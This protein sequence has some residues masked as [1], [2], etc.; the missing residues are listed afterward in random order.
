MRQKVL[1]LNLNFCTDERKEEQILSLLPVL[2]SPFVPI[3]SPLSDDLCVLRAVGD[4]FPEPPGITH[5]VEP[6]SS[7]MQMTL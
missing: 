7:L 2:E 5:V 1:D 3:C 6:L 4:T